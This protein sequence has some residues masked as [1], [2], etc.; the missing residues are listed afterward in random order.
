[1]QPLSNYL[2]NGKLFLFKNTVAIYGKAQ[3]MRKKKNRKTNT[4]QTNIKTQ[5]MNK[6][7]T[8]QNN[9]KRAYDGVKVEDN[10]LNDQ[11]CLDPKYLP[12][13]AGRWQKK[14]FRKMKCPIVERFTNCL[15]MHGRNS[16][17]KL[18]VSFFIFVSLFLCVLFCQRI[19]C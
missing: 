17:K 13:T 8:K 18:Y 6:T 4:K 10:S 7:K 3:F 1:M 12:H 19:F 15:M 11:I 16:G 5:A 2:E 9:D 14:R